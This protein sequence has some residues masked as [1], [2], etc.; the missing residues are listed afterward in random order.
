M[1]FLTL[2]MQV[3]HSLEDEM[4]NETCIYLCLLHQNSD[5]LRRARTDGRFQQGIK[6]SGLKRGF[7]QP[8]QPL[9]AVSFATGIMKSGHSLSVS[10][11]KFRPIILRQ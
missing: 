7:E 10:G 2:C 11:K 1:D 3:F 5:R 4:Y 6:Q 9:C 8:R